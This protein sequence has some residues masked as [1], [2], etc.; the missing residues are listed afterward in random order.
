MEQDFAPSLTRLGR[1]QMLSVRDA[2]GRCVAVFHGMAWVTQEGD[3]RDR[4]LTSGES[5]TFDRDGVAL[6]HALEPTSLVLLDSDE[7]A[8]TTGFVLP[9]TTPGDGWTRSQRHV[10]RRARRL[11][12]LSFGRA[13]QRLASHLRRAWTMLADAV[14]GPRSGNSSQPVPPRARQAG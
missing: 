4:L 7:V 10:Y 9:P 14:S 1:D 5:F 6:I 2:R 8:S 11:R 12:A 3:T 13:M